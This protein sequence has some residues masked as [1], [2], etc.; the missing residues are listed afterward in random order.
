[1]I[2]ADENVHGYIIRSL[3]EEGFEVVSVALSHSNTTAL[4]FSQHHSF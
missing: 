4:F 3:R 1:M 2:L